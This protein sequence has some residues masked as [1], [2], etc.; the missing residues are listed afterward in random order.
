MADRQ[1]WYAYNKDG[2]IMAFWMKGW[3]QPWRAWMK[4]VKNLGWT[5]KRGIIRG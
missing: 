1:L 5:A 3:A 4:A 2:Q